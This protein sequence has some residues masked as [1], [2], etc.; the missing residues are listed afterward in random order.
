V[1]EQVYAQRGSTG[2]SVEW[3]GACNIM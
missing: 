2:L 1:R 3:I